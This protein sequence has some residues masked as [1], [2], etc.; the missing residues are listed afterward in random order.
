MKA[1]ITEENQIS[2]ES[3]EK[4]LEKL[5]ALIPTNILELL[6]ITAE[7]LTTDL[8]K[9]NLD[10][11]LDQTKISEFTV[12]YTQDRLQTYCEKEMKSNV[13]LAKSITY[14]TLEANAMMSSSGPVFS[15]TLDT[16]YRKRNQH[17]SPKELEKIGLRNTTITF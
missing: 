5:E 6:D 16:L 14:T 7:Q 2:C 3:E 13:V 9:H 1:K 12:K 8:T 10:K 4:L 15:N 11:N 17:I